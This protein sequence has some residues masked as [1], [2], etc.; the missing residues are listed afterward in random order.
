MARQSDVEPRTKGVRGAARERPSGE[1]ELAW[2]KGSRRRGGELGGGRI[3]M[4]FVFLMAVG[5][6]AFNAIWLG[7]GDQEPST[8][9]VGD[10]A[11]APRTASLGG[12]TPV[13]TVAPGAQTT[14]I[15]APG[16]TATVISER[17]AEVGLVPNARLFRM[18]VIWRGAEDRMLAGS[19]QVRQGMSMNELI[20]AFQISKVREVTLTFIEGRRLEEQAETI[21]K[22]ASGIDPEQFVL[23]A[24]RAS[25]VYEFLQARPAGTTLEGYL[26]PD[27]Y[28]IPS[29]DTTAD[30]VIH[31]MLRRFGQIVTPQFVAEVRRNTGLPDLTVHQIVTI[32][33]IVEREAAVASE[34][35]RIAS[36][37]L[38]R[39]R[40]GEGLFA[41]PTVQYAIGK[42]GAWWPV[43]RD[44]PRLIAPDSPYNTYV[45]RGLPP[46]P[47]ANPGEASLRAMATP[48]GSG[49]KY[50]VRND[51]RNDGTHVFAATLREHEANRVKYQR[52]G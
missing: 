12:V 1:T 33:S 50:F 18:A 4:A 11:V 48:D 2:R 15:I 7:M 47:I 13:P 25:F 37:Y 20:D 46:G 3:V 36:V 6:F 16:E 5:G 24:R 22:S 41:D 9:A 31:L 40:D 28:R 51:V 26:F 52:P 21:A 34:R 39:F 38:N 35:A 42:T 27:T 43:L 30:D 32:A 29:N 44:S 14:F 23:S 49:F 8:V 19:Y 45:K 17:L 10:R